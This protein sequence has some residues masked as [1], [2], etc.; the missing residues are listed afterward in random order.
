[1]WKRIIRKNHNVANQYPEKVKELE[2]AFLL[3]AGRN[4]VYPMMNSSAYGRP[5]S[6]ADAYGFGKVENAGSRSGL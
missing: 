6:L 3:E 5:V 1:M 2:E 4:N